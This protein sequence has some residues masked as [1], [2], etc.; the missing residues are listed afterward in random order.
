MSASQVLGGIW[1]RDERTHREMHRTVISDQT[2]ETIAT[3]S[4]C[5]FVSALIL[6]VGQRG[7]Y[8]IQ[9]CRGVGERREARASSEVRPLE[10]TRPRVQGAL[11]VEDHDVAA[12]CSRQAETLNNGC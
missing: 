2:F 12:E 4:V 11:G 1:E 10:G 7:S 5:S 8:A 9:V 3:S 6:C